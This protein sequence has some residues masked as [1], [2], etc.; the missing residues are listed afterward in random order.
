M[1]GSNSD[2]ISDKLTFMSFNCEY[3]DSARLL[4]LQ[5]LFLKCDFLL[6]QE[7]GLFQRQF[8][9]FDQLGDNVVTHGVSAMDDTVCLRG[10]PHGGVMIVWKANI[11]ATVT[12][13]YHESKR[14]CAVTVDTG[15]SKFLLVC[16]YMPCDDDR[17]GH[18]QCWKLGKV[19]TGQTRYF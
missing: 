17:P 7:H 19:L 11:N 5:E 6:I 2:C 12:P 3:A 16:I 1:A 8:G 10:R 14:F 4:F 18:N 15:L 13:V 9:W